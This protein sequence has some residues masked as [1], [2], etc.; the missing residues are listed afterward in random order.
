MTKPKANYCPYDDR[1][2]VI[3]NANP[4]ISNA[5]GATMVGCSSTTFGIGR[6]RLAAQGRVREARSTDVIDEMKKELG[7]EGTAVEYKSDDDGSFIEI[8]RSGDDSLDPVDL[9]HILLDR[10]FLKPDWE[11]TRTL[12]NEWGQEIFV[13]RRNRW[14]RQNKA[15]KVWLRPKSLIDSLM[16]P[17]PGLP[18]DFGKPKPFA[19]NTGTMVAL[20]GCWQLPYHNVI[21]AELFERFLTDIHPALGVELGDRH[22]FP[23]ISKFR[24][25]PNIRATVQ[26]CIDASYTGLYRWR[27]ASP[28]THWTMLMGNHDVRFVSEQL[29]RAE[30]IAGISPGTLPGEDTLIP[31]HDLRRA[32]RTDELDIDVIMP[33][34]GSDKYHNSKLTL[35]DR[36][37][38]IHGTKL[39]AKTAVID[40]V[41]HYGCSVA[42][43]H[44]HRQRIS[45]VLLWQGPR[46]PIHAT[47]AEVGTGME[48]GGAGSSYAD[49]P[50]W[51]NGAMTAIIGEDGEP[52]F[53]PIRF[54]PVTNVMRW[55][56]Y[57]WRE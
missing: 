1:I 35:T 28:D 30:R 45:S 54:N 10:G 27:H 47:G 31:L 23:T 53:E 57:E 26:Q 42:M 6:K 40:T 33:P 22:D 34:N 4:T 37:I 29:Q 12:V 41:R 49:C 18:I 51:A 38:A 19:V 55:R 43:A 44:T 25:D 46:D 50:D 39:Q 14:E 2:A 3:V 5:K 16:H 21:F 20:T 36:F 56:D 9:N 52:H 7:K 15:L 8:T 32:L 17:A 48:I 24:D 11:V 13:E